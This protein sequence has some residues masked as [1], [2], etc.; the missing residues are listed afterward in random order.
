MSTCV[1][2]TALH[3]QKS[4][5]NKG[6]TLQLLHFLKSSIK[7]GTTWSNIHRKCSN[8]NNIILTLTSERFIIWRSLSRSRQVLKRNKFYRSD[9]V[10]SSVWTSGILLLTNVF[11]KVCMWYFTFKNVLQIVCIVVFYFKSI[12]LHAMPQLNSTLILHA[13]AVII[14]TSFKIPASDKKL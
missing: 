9:I 8:M 10:P 4:N 14:N 13:G 7:V 2:C 12:S 11:R 5:M 1:R 6:T 3:F